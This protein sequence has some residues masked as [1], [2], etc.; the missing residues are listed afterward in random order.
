MHCEYIM[1]KIYFNVY[2]L[3]NQL[4]LLIYIYFSIKNKWIVKKER[5]RKRNPRISWLVGGGLERELLLLQAKKLTSHFQK[6]FVERELP[7]DHCK[8]LDFYYYKMY[9]I[10]I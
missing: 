1:I 10:W 9:K 6:L 5:E 4:H 8:L 7:F 2:K 3:P